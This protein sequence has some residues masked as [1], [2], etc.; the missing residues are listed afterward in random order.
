MKIAVGLDV[1]S[2][3]GKSKRIEIKT[4]L[5]YGKYRMDITVEENA[6]ENFWR[7]QPKGHGSR[8]QAGTDPARSELHGLALPLLVFF[9]IATIRNST[10]LVKEIAVL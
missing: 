4:N 9:R 7:E 8:R 1:S 3:A 5:A 10:S 2:E 6:D